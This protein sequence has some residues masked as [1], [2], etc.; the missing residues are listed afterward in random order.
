MG[1]GIEKADYI[2]LSSHM[3][4]YVTAKCPRDGGMEEGSKRRGGGG[5]RSKL[6]KIKWKRV[7]RGGIS[8]REGE[9]AGG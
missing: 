8:E 9:G 2:S 1:V 3:P 7:V 5:N 4:D 6:E